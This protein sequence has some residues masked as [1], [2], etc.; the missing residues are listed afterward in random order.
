MR[1]FFNLNKWNKNLDF[2]WF[3]SDWRK[4]YNLF[5]Y[6]YVPIQEFRVSRSHKLIT[7]LS[8]IPTKL[9][10]WVCEISIATST[11]FWLLSAVD[12]VLSSSLHRDGT[13]PHDG[14]SK[15]NVWFGQQGHLRYQSGKIKGILIA[16]LT[17][18]YSIKKNQICTNTQIILF[19]K[20]LLKVA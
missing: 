5:I 2:L 17:F 8:Y 12:L 15:N 10:S 19:D 6:T 11:M 13:T 9:K 4:K 14:A 7:K 18:E 20:T 3:L 1:I 16:E